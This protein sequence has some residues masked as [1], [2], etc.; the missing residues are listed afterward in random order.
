MQTQTF[1]EDRETHDFLIDLKLPQET[2]LRFSGEYE[3][4]AA[5]RLLSRYIAR[6]PQDLRVHAQ[7]ILLVIDNELSEFLPGSL[8]DL[9]IAL[10]GKGKP[11]FKSLLEQASPALSEE[12]QQHYLKAFDTESEQQCWTK[13]SVLANGIC[14]A[15]PLVIFEGNDEVQGFGSVL[16]EAQAYI[17]Y[18][19]L[20][21]ARQLLE[22]E[23][24]NQPRAEDIEEEL[25]Y[26]YQ[27]LRQPGY[28]DEM[29]SNLQAL[30]IELSPR[31]VQCLEDAKSWQ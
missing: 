5:W 22:N 20:E 23:L 28:L 15:N 29:T 7:R 4:I 2:R 31:W 16:E 1:V 19:E 27:S 24:L 13:G 30:D 3:P 12:Q 26:L 11:F 10:S 6:Y 21:E 8:Q 17:E 9:I 25:L 18:G 14:N